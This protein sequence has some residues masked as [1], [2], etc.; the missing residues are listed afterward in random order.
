MIHSLL[1][2]DHRKLHHVFHHDSSTLTSSMWGEEGD[3]KV[4]LSEGSCLCLGSRGHL[5]T[6]LSQNRISH[7]KWVKERDVRERHGTST[8]GHV[9][10]LSKAGDMQTHSMPTVLA[11]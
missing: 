5:L 8:R 9:T 11:V 6:V 10:L 7:L 3:K 4:A 2:L 1:P